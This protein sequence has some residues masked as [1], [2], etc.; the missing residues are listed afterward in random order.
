MCT[1]CISGQ[2]PRGGHI[3]AANAQTSTG[4]SHEFVVSTPVNST[5]VAGRKAAIAK[6]KEISNRTWRGVF[7]ER[8][9]K[10]VQMRY[11]RGKL[12]EY[13]FETRDRAR[14]RS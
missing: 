7:V 8:D 10:R 5:K 13:R 1:P 9:D 2:Q 12:Q 4:G 11:R 6:A 3:S 14:R